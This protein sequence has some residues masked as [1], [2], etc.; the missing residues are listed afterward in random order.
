LAD[1]EIQVRIKSLLNKANSLN[2]RF[3]MLAHFSVNE[4]E[5]TVDS[6]IQQLTSILVESESDREDHTDNEPEEVKVVESSSTST[7]SFKK[8]RAIR[9]EKLLG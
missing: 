2:Q 8:E 4:Q 6:I 9:L 5:K 7:S 3:K 1:I